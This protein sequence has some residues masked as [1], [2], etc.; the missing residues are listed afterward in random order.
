[1]KKIIK[2]LTLGL[3]TMALLCCAL[4][5]AFAADADEEQKDEVIYTIAVDPMGG[6]TSTLVLS[7]N[8]AGRLD[9]LPETPVLEGYTFDGWYTDAVG[10][11]KI[12]TSTTFT[13]D[14]TV[15]AHWTVKAGSS[16][17]I[18]NL[19]NVAGTLKNHLGTLLV[20]GVLLST[21]V[22]AVL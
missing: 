19:P 12:S 1:M 3:L 7:T 10:G 13:Q 18:T 15:Y 22:I 11:S 21:L 16:A 8:L 2:M 9:A 6:T 17:G 4:P 5:A 14:T 20:T